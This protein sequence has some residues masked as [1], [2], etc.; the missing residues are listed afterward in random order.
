MN[1]L[2]KP[3]VITLYPIELESP[4]DGCRKLT[5]VTGNKKLCEY[6][7]YTFEEDIKVVSLESYNRLLR[8]AKEIDEF[9]YMLSLGYIKKQI[10]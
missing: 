5:L 7:T 4:F 2:T 6:K 9:N 3:N 10:K 8:K 1:K